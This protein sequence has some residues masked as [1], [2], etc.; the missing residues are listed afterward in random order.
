MGSYWVI[1]LLREPYLPLVS[2]RMGYAVGL[3][4]STIV[5]RH[6]T[7]CYKTSSWVIITCWKRGNVRLIPSYFLILHGRTK[8]IAQGWSKCGSQVL[9]MTS[10]G[11]VLHDSYFVSANSK[12]YL[13][14][15]FS[16]LSAEG[17]VVA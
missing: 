11:T 1:C 10:M 6:Y 14:S 8:C 16:V 15:V 2:A 4:D 9:E 17:Y 5:P 3:I 7:S 13:V 12:F